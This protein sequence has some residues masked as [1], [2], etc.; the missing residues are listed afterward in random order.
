MPK[1]ILSNEVTIVNNSAI[2]TNS[3]PNE[4]VSINDLLENIRVLVNYIISRKNMKK[5]AEEFI[6]FEHKDLGYINNSL[7]L[8]RKQREGKTLE[9]MMAATL[10]Y[11]NLVEYLASN[12]LDNIHHMVAL[13]S[14]RDFQ[15]IFFA[16]DQEL[17]KKKPPR[18][19]GQLH[20]AL[21][22]YT[23]PDDSDFLRLIKKFSETRN[24]IFHKLLIASKNEL[25]D[26]DK[27]FSE[28]HNM[29]E[30]ILNKYNTMIKGVGNSWNIFVSNLNIVTPQPQVEGL[31]K[32]INS[33]LTTITTLQKRLADIDNNKKLI[34]RDKKN[35]KGK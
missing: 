20:N 6:P 14:Y 27:K 33:L 11:T 31:T 21:S 7:A 29:A 2:C 30:E 26:V 5:I 10:I 24:S 19:L 18:T 17:I 3:I 22:Y 4:I 16:K 32:Q 28:L 1:G 9:G 13:S 25:G 12:L 23:F 35:K 15:G 34:V 8:A